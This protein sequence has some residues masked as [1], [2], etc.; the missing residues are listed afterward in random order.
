M[1]VLVCGS[2]HWTDWKLIETH[3]KML[4]P[5]TTIISGAARGADQMAATIGAKLGLEVQES[6]ADWAKFGRAAGY[7]RNLL[8]LKERPDLVIAFHLDAS[9]GTAHAIENARKRGI[10]VEVVGKY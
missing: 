5:G 8:M 4:P 3:L 7:R 6:P 2:R 9:P 10:P 1:K